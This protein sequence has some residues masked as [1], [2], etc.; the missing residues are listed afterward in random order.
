[1]KSNDYIL[2]LLCSSLGFTGGLVGSTFRLALEL[3]RLA[4][5]L[6]ADLGGGALDLASNLGPGD[7]LGSS[8]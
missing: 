8:S 4:L 3:L 6:A 2:Q 1:M 5:Y 7:L